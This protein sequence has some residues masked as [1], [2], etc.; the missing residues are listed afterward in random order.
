MSWHISSVKSLPEKGASKKV[1]SLPKKVPQKIQKS[2]LVVFF[3]R[4]FKQYDNV[5]ELWNTCEDSS[6][7]NLWF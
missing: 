5:D 2:N 6:V 1:F 3:S 4:I 7:H